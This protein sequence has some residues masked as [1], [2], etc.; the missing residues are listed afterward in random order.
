MSWGKTIYNIV[1]FCME[2]KLYLGQNMEQL[3]LEIRANENNLLLDLP[4]KSIVNLIDKSI[5]ISYQL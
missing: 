5:K 3:I 2:H 1:D 4:S